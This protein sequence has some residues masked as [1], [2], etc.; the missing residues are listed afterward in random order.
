MI[1]APMP[2]GL[3]KR[4][5]LVNERMPMDDAEGSQNMLGINP[6][7]YEQHGSEIAYERPQSSQLSRLSMT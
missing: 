7:K 2:S 1:A 4:N 6:S 3:K 5:S